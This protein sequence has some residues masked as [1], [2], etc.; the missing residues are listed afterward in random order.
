MS[1]PMMTRML[2]FRS[3]A[4]PYDGAIAAS[5]LPAATVIPKNKFRKLI[6]LLLDLKPTPEAGGRMG[7]ALLVETAPL[8]AP[9]VGSRLQVPGFQFLPG[10]PKISQLVDRRSRRR[11]RERIER[12][13][14]HRL[15]IFLSGDADRDAWI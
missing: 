10:R 14:Q 11:E 1:S 12:L 15:Q 7:S 9:G 8:V 2:G 13:G 5:T 3:W 6:S 4:W